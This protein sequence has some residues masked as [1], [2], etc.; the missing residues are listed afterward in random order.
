MTNSDSFDLPICPQAEKCGGCSYQGVPYEE[1]CA[2]KERQVRSLL[3]GAGFDPALLEEFVPCGSRY[4]YR[5]KMEFTFGDEHK[6]GP[7]EL[8]MHK[9]GSFM[10]IVDAGCC[11][12]VPMDFTRVQALVKAFCLERGYS[13]YHKKFHTGLLRSITLRQGMRTGELL[14]NII[15]ASDSESESFDEAAFVKLL[16][17]AE[18]EGQFDARIVGILRTVNDDPADAVNIGELRVLYGQP[19]YMEQIMGLQFKVGAFSFFQTNVDAAERLYMDALSLIP[20]IEGKTVYDLYCGTGTISQAMALKAKKVIGVEIVE[21]A[22][23]SAKA[24]AALN[25]LENCE[26]IADDVQKALSGIHEKPDVIVVDPPRSG[27]TPKA[28]RQILGYNVDQILYISC[29]PRTLMENLRA[30]YLAGYKVQ[31]MKAYD[32]F[33]FTSHV[34]TVVLMTRIK[35]E[36]VMN[37]GSV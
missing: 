15:T 6:D 16:L 31:R 23:V 12:I 7:M 19:F 36:N 3:K 34:E 24:N 5:N 17:D 35:L 13:I 28:M 10:S 4:H 26:F 20:G 25:G 8:G 29:N 1:Q 2:E 27:I 22:V 37:G 30:A 33:P 9:K 21:E 32:N 11:Q 18:K 14:I